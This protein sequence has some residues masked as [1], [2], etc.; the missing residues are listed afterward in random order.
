M[1]H[2]MH[3]HM[4]AEGN[5][6]AALVRAAEN[7]TRHDRRVSVAIRLCMRTHTLPTVAAR[8][9]AE[10]AGRPHGG[11]RRIDGP[12]FGTCGARRGCWELPVLAT[13]PLV[14]LR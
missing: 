10:P 1:Q 6:A 12:E 8:T 13:W 3:V 9:S 14:C 2:A 4:H 5:R 11:R 7:P